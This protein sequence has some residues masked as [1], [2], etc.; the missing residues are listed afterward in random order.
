MPILV[1]G[2]SVNRYYAG[3]SVWTVSQGIKRSNRGLLRISLLAPGP[4]W[5]F[6]RGLGCSCA[7]C[8]NNR[9]AEPV[10]V[11][12]DL[13]QRR[14]NGLTVHT[15]SNPHYMSHLHSEKIIW[16]G[17]VNHLGSVRVRVGC[18]KVV[19]N[20]SLPGNIITVWCSYQSWS[21]PR[22]P[23]QC[24]IFQ[25][26]WRSRVKVKQGQARS[27]KGKQG[28]A[29]SSKAKQGKARS[30]KAKQGQARSSKVKQG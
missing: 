28:Q 11:F 5:L 6:D 24:D 9:S 21:Y 18:A 3:F 7:D 19:Y 17:L 12:Y 20:T 30:S 29:R 1:N 14:L 2:R 25:P 8:R 22:I 13:A 4:R 15:N 16:R 27:S 10:V 23:G 26:F